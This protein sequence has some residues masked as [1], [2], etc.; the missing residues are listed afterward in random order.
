MVPTRGRASLR[1]GRHLRRERAGLHYGSVAGAC[2]S[3]RATFHR[4]DMSP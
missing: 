3:L 1:D 2:L 4:K